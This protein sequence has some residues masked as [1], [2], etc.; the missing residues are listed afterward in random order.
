MSNPTKINKPL[1]LLFI[2]WFLYSAGMLGYMAFNDKTPPH[3]LI[4]E[5]NG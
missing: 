2:T 1:T 3:C 4:L 5:N